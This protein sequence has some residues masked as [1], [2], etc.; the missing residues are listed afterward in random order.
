MADMGFLAN[1]IDDFADFWDP[2]FPGADRLTI[3]PQTRRLYRL[4]I[5][6]TPDHM[7]RALFVLE[8]GCR[9][10]TPPDLRRVKRSGY[11]A[12]EWGLVLL[13]GLEQPDVLVE[14]WR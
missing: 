3:Y 5:D 7:L 8:P 1:E 4:P 14:T 13:P 12:A 2:E 9:S 6:P 11:H 10:V